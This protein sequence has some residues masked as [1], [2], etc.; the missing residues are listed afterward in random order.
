MLDY[1]KF[2]VHLQPKKLAPCLQLPDKPKP[3]WYAM[4]LDLI[5]LASLAGFVSSKV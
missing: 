3:F 5:N 4:K 2:D 1:L